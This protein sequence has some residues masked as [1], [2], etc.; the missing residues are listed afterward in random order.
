MPIIDG[1]AH[2][3]EN[4]RTWDYMEGAESKFRPLTVSSNN[5]ASTQFWCIDGNIF[6]RTSNVNTKLSKASR[7]LLNAKERLKHMDEIGLD[8]QV[9]YPS[10]FL[11][12]LTRRPEVEAALCKSYNRWLSEMC[13]QGE[14]RLH[15]VA[16]PPLLAMDEALNEVR[17]A[18]DNGACGLFVRGLTDNRLFNDPYF[19]PLYEEASRLDLS[20]CVH[21]S[22][23]SFEWLQLFQQEGGFS[24]FKLPIVSTFHTII[25]DGIPE[26]FPALRFGF[27]EVRAQWIPY[28]I[29]DL[30]KRLEQKRGVRITDNLLREKRLYVGC[31]TDDD[32]PFVLK[33]S[34]EDN[35]LIGSDYGHTD[36]AAEIDALKKMREKGDVSPHIIDKILWDNPKA[37]YNI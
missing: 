12:Q 21:A 15:W 4:D 34:G 32:L 9:L 27:L 33:Y 30:K 6:S 13:R 25:Y 26:M 14:D 37:F 22:S 20:I 28:A 2:V 29:V 7:E 18:K 11:G 23:G 10:L 35:L 16:I 36:T 17:F 24:K 1:D 8:I 5:D 3:I 19:Y 31:Q